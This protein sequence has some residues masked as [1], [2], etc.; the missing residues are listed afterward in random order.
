LNFLYLELSSAVIL[1]MKVIGIC[2]VVG[3]TSP[4]L[5]FWATSFVTILPCPRKCSLAL[6]YAISNLGKCDEGTF[7][8]M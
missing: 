1:G 4:E 3:F 5:S 6:H 7:L 8:S 2:P